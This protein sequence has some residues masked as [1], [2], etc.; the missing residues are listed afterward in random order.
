MA[1]Q[2]FFFF[3]KEDLIFLLFSTQTEI[4][5]AGQFLLFFQKASLKILGKTIHREFSEYCSHPEGR[6]LCT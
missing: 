5:G 4:R 3:L 2:G 1:L 6:Q